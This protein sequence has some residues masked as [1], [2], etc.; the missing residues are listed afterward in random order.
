MRVSTTA[1]VAPQSELIAFVKKHV[2]G[3]LHI[4]DHP[5]LAAAWVRVYVQKCLPPNLLTRETM[6]G[7]WL[8]VAELCTAV[9]PRRYQNE[10]MGNLKALIERNYPKALED[11]KNALCV[12]K[13]CREKRAGIHEPACV[14]HTCLY[15]KRF[16]G[17]DWRKTHALLV[18][19]DIYKSYGVNVLAHLVPLAMLEEGTQEAYYFNR[20]M[21]QCQAIWSNTR[22]YMTTICPGDLGPCAARKTPGYYQDPRGCQGDACI[23]RVVGAKDWDSLK[24]CSRCWALNQC[25]WARPE[26]PHVLD[27]TNPE[28]RVARACA[29]E[30]CNF[31]KQCIACQK[32]WFVP[33]SRV[34]PQGL[35]GVHLCPTCRLDRLCCITCK[36]LSWKAVPGVFFA[37][38][39]IFGGRVPSSSMAIGG[40]EPP[41]HCVFCLPDVPRIVGEPREEHKQMCI[42]ALLIGWR[43]RGKTER[44]LFESAFAYDPR[45]ALQAK[46]GD[47]L[48]RRER[49][50]AYS[51]PDFFWNA[52]VKDCTLWDSTWWLFYQTA[53][54]PRDVFLIIL[55]MV[56]FT[57]KQ[58]N[59]AAAAAKSKEGPGTTK[60]TKIKGG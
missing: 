51:Q 59:A 40:K 37:P 26:A 52:M 31:G 2:T 6:E 20:L 41:V 53:R 23:P 29:D 25:M 17:P 38:Q 10:L 58:R 54:L 21:E 13:E 8:A 34:G 49:A 36:R 33:R 1:V 28:R 24:F 56:C 57:N 4:I 55:R 47:E 12:I 45:A 5:G 35:N 27:P 14:E 3:N 11:E 60:G 15:C 30:T 42:R 19:G 9:L 43:I 44:I 32:W 48:T 50:L 18:P 46:L 16:I 22:V 39:W 7:G